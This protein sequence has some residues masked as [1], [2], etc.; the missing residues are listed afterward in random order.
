MSDYY[1]VK[2]K[3]KI[4]EDARKAD[5]RRTD[6]LIETYCTSDMELDELMFGLKMI[7]EEGKE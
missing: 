3:R 4:I 7:A 2:V 6:M 5:P 1:T